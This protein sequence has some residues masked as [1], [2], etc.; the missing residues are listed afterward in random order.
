MSVSDGEGGARVRAWRP[1]K[2]TRV[3]VA[4]GV[5]EGRDTGEGGRGVARSES[6]GEGTRRGG[7]EG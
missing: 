2:S 4:R 1:L 3:G 5:D 6:T 7:E